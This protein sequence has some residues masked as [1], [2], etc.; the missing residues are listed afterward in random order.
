V[1]DRRTD[2]ITIT[3]ACVQRRALK[4]Y[5]CMYEG[6]ALHALCGSYVAEKN[7]VIVEIA[8]ISYEIN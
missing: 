1:T 8:I 7:I 6:R 4:I 5:S 2:R 3:A